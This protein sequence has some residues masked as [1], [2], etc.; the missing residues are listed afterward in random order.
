[1]EEMRVRYGSRKFLEG[2]DRSGEMETSGGKGRG[3]AGTES[4]GRK[5]QTK[6]RRDPRELPHV[7]ST[8]DSNTGETANV[9]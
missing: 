7:K 4:N 3:V 2:A 6:E 9:R 1:M 8:N 5:L